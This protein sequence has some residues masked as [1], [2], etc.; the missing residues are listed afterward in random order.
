MR[1]TRIRK[2]ENGLFR[3]V[4][5]LSHRK[6]IRTGSPGFLRHLALCDRSVHMSLIHQIWLKS[7]G[8]KDISLSCRKIHY[9]QR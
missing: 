3:E 1:G 8:L 7:I 4:M 5:D 9:G 6:L 2:Y